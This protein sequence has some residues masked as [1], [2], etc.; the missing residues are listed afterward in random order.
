MKSDQ[1]FSCNSAFNGFAIYRMEKILG[2]YYGW[3]SIDFKDI[4][5]DFL[6]NSIE[7]FRYLPV[8]KANREDCEHREFHR[9]M[10]ENHNAKIRICPLPI[11]NYPKDYGEL[12]NG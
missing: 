9:Q 11:F 6:I 10:I 5:L 1:L 12:V 7:S 3:E 2:C 4:P 8:Y